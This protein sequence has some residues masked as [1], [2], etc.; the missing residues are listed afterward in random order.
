MKDLIIQA[1]SGLSQFSIILLTCSLCYVLIWNLGA[2][3]FAPYRLD[4]LNDSIARSRIKAEIAN[5]LINFLFGALVINF[6]D[7]IT[8]KNLT[9][10][11]G[12]YKSIDVLASLS[13]L[14]GLFFL[15]DIWF[16]LVHRALHTQYLFKYIHSIHHKSKIV[17]PFSSYS[18]HFLE[19]FML[20]LWAFPVLWLTS[21]DMRLLILMQFLGTL[22]TIMSHLG[23]EFFPS[24]FIKTPVLK[25]LNTSTFHALHHIRYD[26]NYALSTRIW[27]RLFHT[28]HPHYEEHFRRKNIR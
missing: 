11:L 17:N 9:A 7:F 25:Y 22:S 13:W 15:N 3:K 21:I 10:P 8:Q 24:W 28:E 18:M 5:T 20:T 16:Y 6:F 12:D 23:H 27:D 19:G 1:M 26:C 4:P 14:I 2:K